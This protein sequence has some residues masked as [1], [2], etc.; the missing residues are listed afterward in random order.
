MTQISNSLGTKVDQTF[1]FDRTVDMKN[2]LL[3]QSESVSLKRIKRPFCGWRSEHMYKCY[4]YYYYFTFAFSGL[5]V[6]N[7]ERIER[8]EWKIRNSELIITRSSNLSR[9]KGLWVFKKE[10]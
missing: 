1:N 9:V 3:G 10:L 8:C 2:E 6:N 5:T 7:L 4:V